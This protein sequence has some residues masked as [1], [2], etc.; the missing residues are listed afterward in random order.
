MHL[1]SKTWHTLD[2][3]QKNLLVNGLTALAYFLA[4]RLGLITALTHPSSTAVW[5]P[6]GIAIALFL[7]LGKRIWPGVAAGSFLVNIT[8]EGAITAASITTS[9][10]ISA[11]NT[12]EALAGAYLVSR[13]ANGARCFNRE[14]DTFKFAF[15]AG[16]VCTT[17]AATMGATALA[18]GG[19]A[20]W[21]DYKL[22][23]L[24]WWLGD[25][26]G[27]VLV[28]PLMLLWSVDTRLRWRWAKWSEL[29]ILLTSLTAVGQIVF[30]PFAHLRSY[31]LEYLCIPFLIW[32]AFRF[33]PREAAAATLV[34]SVIAI[35]GTLHGFGPFAVAKKS[36]SLLLLQAFMSIVGLMTLALG[37]M[38]AERMRAEDQIRNLAVTDPL[39]GLA[40]YRK[41]I[42]VLD[43]EIKRFDRTGRPFAVL[44]FDMDGL[45]AINDTHGHLV[46]SRAIRR[47][48]DILRVHCRDID[49]AA[50]YGG[51]EFVLV[52][53]ESGRKQ[54]EL[55][56]QRIRLR[57]LDD[58]EKPPISASIGFAVYPRDGETRDALLEA[59]DR[60]LYDMKN[61]SREFR[62][63]NGET[64]SKN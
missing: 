52:L 37:V 24:A 35:H 13:F 64:E 31:P 34:L 50:R 63:A 59:A 10:A 47:L 62:M 40:N 54:A 2:E 20:K 43:L 29:A 3:Q 28:A 53:P 8:S 14:Q 19:F 39:T 26:A 23:W 18:I 15:F 12:L 33:G 38:S 57:V 17:I 5:P 7:I 45:K 4:G 21:T 42:D 55:V 49:T 1:G 46:G 22:I 41:L 51:D 25:A 44:L 48:G 36:A 27:V 60:A 16:F 61:R 6:T 58:A 32:A 9:I 30:G 11:G 56:M